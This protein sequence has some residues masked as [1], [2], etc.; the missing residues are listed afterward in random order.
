VGAHS[1]YVLIDVSGEQDV[2]LGRALASIGHGKARLARTYK[3]VAPALHTFFR[4]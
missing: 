1:T 3:N 4:A 2:E